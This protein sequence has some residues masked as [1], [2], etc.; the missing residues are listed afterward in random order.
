MEKHNCCKYYIGSNF[1][2]IRFLWYSTHYKS[3]D[4]EYA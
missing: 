2:S 1:T 4:K 3:I